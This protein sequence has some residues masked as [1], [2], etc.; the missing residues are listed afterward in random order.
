MDGW[1]DGWMDGY[2][3][4]WMVGRVARDAQL[5]IIH[6]SIAHLEPPPVEAHDEV[7]DGLVHVD[8]QPLPERR[9]QAGARAEQL[10]E[11]VPAD[12]DT[13]ESSRRG[14]L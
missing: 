4:G 5:S 6:R 3:D 11:A 13:D 1:M 8:A 10:G 9:C 2:M 14:K 12:R 7:S